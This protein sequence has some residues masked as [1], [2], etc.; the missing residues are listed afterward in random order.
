MKEINEFKKI[1]EGTSN[2]KVRLYA[3]TSQAP[4]IKVF[5]IDLTT[6]EI[7]A[8][9]NLDMNNLSAYT[10]NEMVDFLG[11]FIRELFEKIAPTIS[12][13]KR[14]KAELEQTILE[15]VNKFTRDTEIKIDN[16]ELIKY[17]VIRGSQT[18]RTYAIKIKAEV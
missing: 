2:E 10:K 17:E 9:E 7:L 16:I 18:G 15:E 13:I 11:E 6:S 12:Y 14:R 3:D 5:V 8:T 1:L 4:I